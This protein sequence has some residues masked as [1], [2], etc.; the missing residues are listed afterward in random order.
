MKRC[1]SGSVVLVLGF[2]LAAV[3][4]G[5][6]NVPTLSPTSEATVEATSGYT[7]GLTSGGTP[8]TTVTPM[9]TTFC[10]F[11][12]PQPTACP[13]PGTKKITMTAPTVMEKHIERT[14]S[15]NFRH[16]YSDRSIFCAVA[17]ECDP[18]CSL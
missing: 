14:T 8:G 2:L 15:A 5:F 10:N 4:S 18:S 16:S 9:P 1:T 11:P 17:E 7:A 12:T 13:H 3:V 6:S